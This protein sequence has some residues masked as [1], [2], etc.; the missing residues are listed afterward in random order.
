M[1]D[2]IG[3]IGKK[4]CEVSLN[5]ILAHKG[6]K[7]LISKIMKFLQN[8]KH[9]I[10]QLDFI[11]DKITKYKFKLLL[12]RDAEKR[13]ETLMGIPCRGTLVTDLVMSH[14]M[15]CLNAYFRENLNGNTEN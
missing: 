2:A 10:A 5:K 11:P 1:F 14:T 13:L 4:P 8:L 9:D 15:C 7:K 12:K 3:T 6:D